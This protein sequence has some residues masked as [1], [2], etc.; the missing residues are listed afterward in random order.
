MNVNPDVVVNTSGSLDPGVLLLTGDPTA[1]STLNMQAGST[2]STTDSGAFG[3]LIASN[4]GN[5]TVTT[6]QITTTG[7]SAVGVFA[8]SASGTVR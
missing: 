3:V 5:L 1:A 2:I 4:A 8:S 7:T 6:S